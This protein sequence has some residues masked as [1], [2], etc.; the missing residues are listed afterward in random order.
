MS[1]RFILL[2]A[3]LAGGVVACNGD[4]K[5]YCEEANDCEGGND[6]D[7]EACV[8]SINYLEEQAS[9]YGCEDDFN[10]LWECFQSEGTCREV[11][12]E[13]VWTT[14]PETGDDP[15]DD[16]STAFEACMDKE[17]SLDDQ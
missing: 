3:F 14:Q 16:D 7:E 17:S 5:D 15:C 2:T 1:M 9:I 8:A 6:K 4:K 11:G 10:D 13:S 12:N